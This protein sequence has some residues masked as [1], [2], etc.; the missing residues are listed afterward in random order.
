MP[1]VAVLTVGVMA[2]GAGISGGSYQLDKIGAK[3]SEGS[4]V[5]VQCADVW[6]GDH[7]LSTIAL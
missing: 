2:A 7:L 6:L 4:A 1:L 5:T 3:I